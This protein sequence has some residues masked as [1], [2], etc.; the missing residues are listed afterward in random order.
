MCLEHQPI[1]T[2]RTLDKEM[3]ECMFDVATQHNRTM[4]IEDQ[5]SLNRQR[6]EKLRRQDLKKQEG[7]DKAQNKLIDT[8]L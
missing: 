2:I 3:V 5:I 4:T 1:G 6:K 7:L 8:R